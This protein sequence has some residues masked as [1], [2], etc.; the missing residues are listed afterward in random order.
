MKVYKFGGASVKDANGIRNLAKIV[1]KT[2]REPLMIV[3]SAM[4]KSTNALERMLGLR[5]SG[6]SFKEAFETFKK[7]HLHICRE[8]ISDFEKVKKL[9]NSDF[10]LLEYRL[11]LKELMS[12]DYEYDQIVSMGEI[13]STKIIH[14]Y[15]EE[16][17]LESRWL[18]ARQLILTDDN[19]RAARVQLEKTV[20]TIREASSNYNGISVVQGFIAHN[21]LGNTTTLGREGSDYTAALLAYALDVSEVTI[22]KDVDGVYNADPKIFEKTKLIPELSYRDAVE[23]AF[24][25]ASIIHPKT[26]QPL[27]KKKINL[28]VRSFYYPEKLGTTVASKKKNENLPSSFIVKKN[29][30]LIS[31][32]PRDFSFMDAEN[33]GLAF[34][35]LAKH[36]HH[37]NLIQ[38]SAIS[39]SVC[40]D[41][42]HAHF[43][44]LI[45]E[46]ADKFELRYN[47]NQVLVTIRHYDVALIEKIYDLLRFKLE[48]RNRS[49]YQVLMS[50]EEF[51]LKLL[52]ILN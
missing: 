2:D 11:G 20:D 51:E 6:H 41:F 40:V 44:S 18:D 13:F 42:N 10:N 34:Q 50:E 1:S 45:Q 21:E 4:G 28:R 43:H 35:I 37:I 25:G 39:F 3:V 19:Y 29:Q 15:M 7:Q 24:Y 22:W 9:L 31:L 48:Q 47:E 49:T 12:Y 16:S 14:A 33:M 32:V 36:Q 30:V 38:N 27:Q 8:L 46:L 23:L 17:R 5:F 26:I 52:P